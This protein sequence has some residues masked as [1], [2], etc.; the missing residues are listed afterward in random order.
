[1][2]GAAFLHDPSFTQL[3]ITH[4]FGTR[5]ALPPAGV[6]RPRQVHGVEVARVVETKTLT[7][8]AAHAVVSTLPGLPVAVVT[9][10]CVPIL[11]ASTSGRAVAAVHAGW[12]GLAAGIVAAAARRLGELSGDET[13]VAG[14]GP[15]GEPLPYGRR[16][17]RPRLS[18]ALVEAGVITSMIFILP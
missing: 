11:L 6:V 9:A 10:D 12:R 15:Q 4:G 13:L 2:T 3:G 16:I 5:G 1:M 18:G 17:S 8:D 14:I 7:V